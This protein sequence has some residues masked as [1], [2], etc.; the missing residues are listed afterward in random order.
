METGTLKDNRGTVYTL[1]TEDELDIFSEAYQLELRIIIP[2]FKNS[3]SADKTFE[4]YCST[5][6]QSEICQSKLQSSN[7]ENSHNQ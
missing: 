4:A 1:N 2:D 7:I 6:G 3:I 5:Y